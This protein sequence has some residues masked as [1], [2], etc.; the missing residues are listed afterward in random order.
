MVSQPMIEFGLHGIERPSVLCLGAH[1]DDIEIGC[2]GALLEMGKSLDAASLHCVIFSSNEVREAETRAALKEIAANWSVVTV[3][4]HT[5]R[6][7]YFPY[8][9][10]EIKDAFETLKSNANPD[11]VFTHYREDRHQDHRLISDLT[12]N[13][14]RDHAILE[15]EI[16]K[17]DGDLG[18]PNAFVEISEELAKKK[19]DCLQRCFMSQHEKSWF[20]PENFKALMR[21]RS[22]ECN[23]ESGFAEAYYS[24]KLKIGV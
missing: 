13:T 21:I 14:F 7:G 15:Y 1:C 20:K 5:F 3:E 10:N 12:W 19:V 16:L 17:F 18:R 9:A 4:L 23:A 2:G 11:L 22:V 6:N 8:V 24:R